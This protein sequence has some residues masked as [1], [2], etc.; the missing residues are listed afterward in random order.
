MSFSRAPRAVIV[1]ASVAVT[2]LQGDASWA[3]HW[4]DWAATD[5]ILLAPAHFAAEVANALLRS[6]RRPAAEVAIDMDRLA[7]SGVET[8]DRHLPGLLEA[9]GLAD[10]HGLTVYDALYLQ[11]ALDVGGELVTL[12]VDLG[13]AAEAEGVSR[14]L[15]G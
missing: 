4:A 13:R 7:R 9:I 10:E 11:L 5:A 1:D 3:D 2:F 6:A 15:L 12:D 8:V 14:T